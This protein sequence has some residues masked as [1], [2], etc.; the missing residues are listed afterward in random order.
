MSSQRTHSD[1]GG[2]AAT[3]YEAVATEVRTGRRVG[4]PRAVGASFPWIDL[5]VCVVAPNR[6]F[7]SGPHMRT[8]AIADDV[9][10]QRHPA[11]GRYLNARRSNGGATRW[12]AS[13][14][15]RMSANRGFGMDR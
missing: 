12:P 4:V 1:G 11:S 7:E 14:C 3:A 2:F 9:P 15:C 13:D 5:T 10:N 8:S 6:S